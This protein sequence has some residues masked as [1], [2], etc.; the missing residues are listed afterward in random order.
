MFTD[1]RR[2]FSAAEDRSGQDRQIPTRGQRNRKERQ[3]NIQ[4]LRVVTC[5]TLFYAVATLA[6][7]SDAQIFDWGPFPTNDDWHGILNWSGGDI[8]NPIPNTT[9]EA[10]RIQPTEDPFQD[11]RLYANVVIGG[12]TIQPDAVLR[13]N[14]FSLLVNPGAGTEGVTRIKGG[15]RLYISGGTLDTERLFVND[16]G[17]L[18][19]SDDGLTQVDDTGSISVGGFVFLDSGTI[20]GGSLSVNG[21]IRIGVFSGSSDNRVDSNVTLTGGE[22]WFNSSGDHSLRLGGDVIMD[23]GSR[24]RDFGNPVA[25]LFVEGY[26]ENAGG[27]IDVNKATIETGALISATN[28]PTM[29]FGMLS[30]GGYFDLDS[31]AVLSVGFGDADSTFDGIIQGDGHLEKTGHGTLTLTG[32]QTYVGNTY[33]EAG[34]LKLDGSSRLRDATLVFVESDGTYQLDSIPD[35]IWGLYGTGHVQLN[36]NTTLVIGNS[37]NG[38]GIGT[39][40]GSMAG[41]GRLVKRGSGTFTLASENSYS[42]QTLVTEGTLRVTNGFN[43][44]S[45]SGAIHVEPEGILNIDG[46]SVVGDVMTVEGL[47]QMTGGS[48]EVS[49]ALDINGGTFEMTGGQLVT[50]S[51]FGDLTMDGGTLAIPELESSTD[52]SG[53]FTLG[54][55]ATLE[56]QLFGEKEDELYVQEDVSLSGNLDLQ[57][58]DTSLLSDGQQFRIIYSGGNITGQFAG[59][60]DGDVVGGVNGIELIINY[61]SNAVTMVAMAIP[62]DPTKIDFQSLQHVDFLSLFHGNQYSEDGFTISGPNLQSWGTLANRY[63]GSTALYS[64]AS[65]GV[66]T[67]TKDDGG[68]FAM[69]SINLAEFNPEIA[70]VNFVGQ[71]TNGGTT[72]QTFTLDGMAFGQE[73]FLFDNSFGNVT[74]VSWVQESPFHQFDDIVFGEPSDPDVLLGDVNLDGLVNLL[75]V[76]PFIS[77]LG[78]GQYQA[79]ADNNQ[80]GVVNLLDVDSFIE[81]ISGV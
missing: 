80:D 43:S 46:G 52:I 22:F 8:F 37:N 34:T 25:H 62:N 19:V 21:N 73:T 67:L 18:Y 15:G 3:G 61:E 9:S 40:E 55:A 38:G 60:A 5:L 63:S 26:L 17:R 1:C 57:I 71:L 48:L 69:T 54:S 58:V 66:T 42:G 45:G 24:V 76:Q 64:G 44:A 77:V 35:A 27:N 6:T 78:A 41:T 79:E 23:M 68:S 31:T 74:S 13:Q 11:P 49:N 70:D 59:L 4:S 65:N 10:A 39:F 2:R 56:I 7:P 30:G 51:V 72:S 53:N 28:T 33:I 20:E 81:L 12:L 75:D 32:N 36:G 16:D 14:G 47:V 50:D 29:R